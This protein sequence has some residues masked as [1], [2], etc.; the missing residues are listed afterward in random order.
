MQSPYFSIIIPTYNCGDKLARSLD[1]ALAQDADYEILIMDGASTDGT[2]EIIKSYAKR[3]PDL[4]R[5]VSEKDAGVYDAMNKGI[6]LARGKYLYF[7]GAGDTLRPGALAR[8]R[9]EAPDQG[10]AFVYGDVY[11]VSQDRICKGEFSR[12]S[13]VHNNLCHQVIFYERSVFELV[14]KY[15]TRYPVLADWVLNMRCFRAKAIRKVYVKMIVA[16]YEGGGLSEPLIDDAFYAD[17]RRLVSQVLGVQM[18]ERPFFIA[19]R[20]V[21]ERIES[22]RTTVSRKFWHAQLWL[23]HK[24]VRPLLPE[25]LRVLKPDSSLEVRYIIKMRDEI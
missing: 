3:N 19:E 16:D 5:W 24:L 20:Y 18:R 22:S 4:I 25:H 11:Y 21:A 23:L 10:A 15:E 14:G 13:F 9:K 8:I 2:A 1:S 12:P 7:L 6:D 17:R